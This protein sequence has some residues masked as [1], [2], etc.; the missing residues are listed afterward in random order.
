MYVTKSFTG[1]YLPTEHYEFR[2]LYLAYSEDRIL[3]YS[4]AQ[5][6]HTSCKILVS[7]LHIIVWKHQGP[8]MIYI[9]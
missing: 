9:K 6:S 7:S 4:I 2:P 5:I 3:S 1:L 8:E